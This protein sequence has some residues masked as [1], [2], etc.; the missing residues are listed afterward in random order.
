MSDATIPDAQTQKTQPSAESRTK[1]VATVGPACQSP[2]MLRE[3]IRTG[4]D[5]FRINTAHG[6]R[7]EHQATLN[8]IR[9]ASVDC[10]QTVGILVDLAGPKIRLGQLIE[11]PTDCPLGAEFRFVR[12]E[13]PQNANEFTCTYESLVTELAVGNRVML[14]DGTVSL[15]VVEKDEASARCVVTGAGFVRSRQGVNLPGV[16]LSVPAL[17]EADISNAIWAAQAGADFISLSFVRSPVEVRQLKELVRSHD[18]RAL[19]IAKIE[20][21]EALEHLDEIVLAAGGVMVARGDLGVEIDLAET[22]VVQKRIIEVCQRLAKPVIVA[23][24]MLDSMEDSPRPTRAEVSDIANAILDGADACM[25]SGE[26]AIG[27]YPREA[28]D[29]MHRVMLSTERTLTR[30]SSEQVPIA[31]LSGVHPITAATVYG[32]TEIASRVNAKLIVIASNG[33]ATARV[34]AKFRSAIP[35]VGVSDNEGTLRRMTLFWGILPLPGAPVANGPKLRQF[36]DN[37]GRAAGVLAK[38]DRVV[39]VTGSEVIAHAHNVVVVQEVE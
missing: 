37:W 5:V 34:K 9:K 7:A 39:Y 33:G 31:A 18:S 2:E 4:V 21:G 25:L 8:A 11:D 13:T 32:A 12:G 19:V 24:Q 1:I 16:A 15:Q 26:T 14:A 3:L 36:I 30:M 27:K 29:V 28:V 22:P 6:T 17:T 23:T 35:V 10:E 20:K 38:G